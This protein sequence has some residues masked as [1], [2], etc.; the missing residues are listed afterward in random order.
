MAESTLSGAYSDFREEIA[1]YLGY[2]RDSSN[3]TSDQESTILS[4]LKSGL[5]QF[6]H[7]PLLPGDA[8]T[9][10]WSFLHP[11][12]TLD[13]GPTTG[14]VSGT[15][16]YDAGT[17]LS[18]ITATASIFEDRM[19][20]DGNSTTIEFDTSGNSYTISS[21][22]SA[23]VVVVSGDASSE[24]ADDGITIS[25]QYIYDLPDNY[26]GIDG[27][28][29]YTSSNMRRVIPVVSELF[30]RKKRA[31]LNTT[32]VPDYCAVRPKS[33]DNTSGQRYEVLF[34]P[35]PSS[36]YTL[37]YSYIP[38]M[39][40]L[41]ASAPYPWGGEP[42]TETIIASCL[43]VAEERLNDT[44]G[45][46]WNRFMERLRASVDFDRRMNTPETLGYVRDG[47][48]RLS[49]GGLSDVRRR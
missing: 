34:Y 1:F 18:T 39:D 25:G 15:P 41:T 20:D 11:V 44:R 27:G 7:P 36:N 3:W 23:T 47:S 8:M 37:E 30:I 17:G 28:F 12:S 45:E 9:Y 6:Y 46:K 33:S 26:G 40:V 19:D 29:T 24:T 16:T 49:E 21:V 13:I 35:R 48:K 22:T 31:G 38:L 32:G 2:G 5:R 4:I 43:A 10:D 14:T 42:H